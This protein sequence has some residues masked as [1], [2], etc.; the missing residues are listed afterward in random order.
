MGVGW[1]AKEG[2]IGRGGVRRLL[3]RAWSL[4]HGETIR[5]DLRGGTSTSRA[6]G[7]RAK[8]WLLGMRLGTTILHAHNNMP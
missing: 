3:G 7:S 4:L 1:H 2:V 6:E 5:V 8:R